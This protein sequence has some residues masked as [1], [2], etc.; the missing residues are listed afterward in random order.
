MSID[1][2]PSERTGNSTTK[3][4]EQQISPNSQTTVTN[5]TENLTPSSSLT[6]LIKVIIFFFGSIKLN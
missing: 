1:E 5:S 4:D 2:Y 3:N 6:S